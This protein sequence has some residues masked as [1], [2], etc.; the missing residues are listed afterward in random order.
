MADIKPEADRLQELSQMAEIRH[1]FILD[2]V[3]RLN[4]GLP[5]YPGAFVKYGTRFMLE[6]PDAIWEK[7]SKARNSGAP[8]NVLDD[9][10]NEFYDGKYMSDAIALATAKKLM[11]VEPFVHMTTKQVKDLGVDEA[12]FKAKLYFSEWLS[13]KTEA[14][15]VTATVEALKQDLYSYT[16]SRKTGQAA[17]Q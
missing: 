1:K 17:Q 15:I 5:N 4:M 11:Y 16:G 3:I 6:S 7:Y 10:L 12:D 13:T 2:H 8:Q 14:Q 9:M